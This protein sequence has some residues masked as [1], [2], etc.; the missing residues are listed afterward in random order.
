MFRCLVVAFALF[1]AVPLLADPP[2]Q[3]GA[4]PLPLP[5]FPQNN[6]WNID[7]SNA[8]IDP[9]SASYLNYIGLTKGLHP[10]F[11]GNAA[12]PDY[13]YGFPFLVVDSN[14]AKKTVDFID[15]DV[16]TEC[17]GVDH[18][19]NQPF[20][21]Y[22]VPDEA[23]TTTGWI[24]GGPAGNIDIRG[25]SDRH[26]LIVDKTNNTLYELY[27]VWHNGTVW[28][29]YSG[30]FF[31]MNTNNR[32]PN[33]WTSGD[34]AGLAILP[35]LVRYDEV[36]GLDEIRHAFRFTTIPTADAYVYPASHEAG[37]T[38][39][40]PPMGM[41]LRLKAS[42]NISGFNPEM[43]KIFRAMKKY[44]LILADNGS[45]MYIS[46][47]YDTRWNND[48]LNP[49]FG[50]LKTSDFEVVQLG[51]HPAITFVLTLPSMMGSGQATG[52]TLTAYDANYNVA[53]GY[54]GTVHFT[55]TDGTATLP[56]D[57]TFMPADAGAHAF[58]SG[59]TL[60]TAG[61]QI[62]TFTDVVTSTNSGSAGVRV[63]PPAP[64]GLNAAATGTTQIMI[65]WNPSSGATQYELVRGSN[66][67]VVTAATNYVDNS[68]AAGTSY[69][70]KV[71][72][73]DAASNPSPYSA[74]DA[75]TTIFFTDDPLIA[76]LTEIKSVHLT[77]LRTAV[78][79][80]RA[81]A[82]L[83]ASSFTDPSPAIVKAAHVTELRTALDAARSVLGLPALAYTDS[84]LAAD[85]AVKATHTQ[86]LRSGVK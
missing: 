21:F 24:E 30:A 16:R 32:R 19:T 86:E 6:W 46:G 81:A 13:I 20:P 31:N 60:N 33:G 44:G 47:T 84:A 83:G 74:R 4:I 29:A 23:I 82:S 39:G 45:D 11:G 27:N 15:E 61:S 12:E 59:F 49:A 80:M 71:R 35:G 10:D 38:A 3:G 67:P 52:A 17:D 34:A 76:S 36:Y 43:Q 8:P 78:N 28:E 1:A 79:A 9:S 58:P 40:A 37:S 25:D 7:V 18:T 2:V 73:L 65:S 51:W 63:G 42:K 22:P 75:A 70:Y 85:Y 55:S 14:Q 50:A 77:E 26:V 53:T 68:V 5:L 69:V 56:P 72:A 57:Y 62:V 54:T 48:T 64:T 41:R 66:A